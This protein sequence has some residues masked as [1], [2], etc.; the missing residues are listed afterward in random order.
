MVRMQRDMANQGYAAGVAAA[1]TAASGKALRE[2]D[3]KALQR[4]LA[5]IGSLPEA[6]LEHKDN[7]PL[8]MSEI[9]Q[10]VQNVGFATNPDEAGPWLAVILT[11]RQAALPL[12]K[13]RFE[14]SPERRKLAYANILAFLGVREVAPALILALDAVKKWDGRILQGRMAEYAHLPTPIDTL[15]LGL[16]RAGDP[17][18]LPAL[19]RKLETL[20]ASVTLSHHRSLA[21]A[22]EQIGDRA[23]AEPLARLL[24]KPG[25]RGHAMK[26]LEPMHDGDMQ[27]RRR[28]G[29]MREIAI[30]R[31][32]YRCGD[33]NGVGEAVLKEYQL[34]VRG[35]FA[36]HAS[37]VLAAGQSPRR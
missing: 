27:L 29:P 16:G 26:K 17:D 31:A 12:L 20:D 2:L 7:F 23:A 5:E 33:H 3:V 32:L 36:R 34:D 11:H 19:L 15:I 1:M 9:R 4:H 37:A 22:L 10:A 13:E 35:L 14:A 24:A 6:A 25:I 18:A 8:P 30:A 28:L 21:I